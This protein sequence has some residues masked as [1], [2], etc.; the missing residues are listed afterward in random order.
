MN[1][2]NEK[3]MKY[4]R[5]NSEWFHF[6][7]TL[8]IKYIDIYKKLEECY[9]QLVH[10]QKRVLL[11]EMLENVIVRMCETKAVILIFPEHKWYPKREISSNLQQVVKYNTQ[12]DAT[13][14]SDY[15]NLDELVMDLKLTPDCLDIPIPRYFREEDK[16]RLD[17]RNLLLD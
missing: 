2:W 13:L 6:W 9:D 5:D 16:K 4:R 1:V 7:A 10:P 3:K 12:H 15:P 14:R 17:E 11:K 8:Y